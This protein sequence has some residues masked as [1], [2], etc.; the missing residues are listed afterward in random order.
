M[1]YQRWPRLA[2]VMLVLLLALGS[3]TLVF[4]AGPGKVTVIVSSEVVPV[5]EHAARLFKEKT[6]SD[7]EIVSQGYNETLQKIVTSQAAGSTAYDITK[8]DTIWVA[9]FAKSGFLVPLDSYFSTEFLN[10][11]L[12]ASIE[13]MRYQGKLWALGG[14]Y[15]AKFLYYNAKLLHDAGFSGPPPTWEDL[16]RQSKAMQSKGL[17]KFGTAWG[18]AQ[19]EGLVA[20]FTLLLNDFG[21]K[22]QDAAGR[23]QLNGP[24]AVRTL[25]FMRDMLVTDK[26]ADP[27]SVTLTD[28]DVVTLFI[29]GRI[30]FLVSWTFAWAWSQDPS[31]SKIP[32]DTRIALVP[33]T[34]EAR[35]VSSSTGGGSGHGILKNSR[36]KERAAQLLRIYVSPEMQ[37]WAIT[38]LKLDQITSPSVLRDP[39]VVRQSPELADFAKQYRH[40]YPRPTL[41]WYAQWSNVMQLDLHKAL[42]GEMSPKQA[43]DD[44]QRQ[45][46]ELAKQFK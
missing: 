11:T 23:W 46:E 41:P 3:G 5:W 25:T 10:D 15:N 6:G 20:D 42:V 32:Y 43:L 16:V 35:T 18:W 34:A 22:Y 45:I 39:Q 38:T 9:Q 24:A 44:A 27:S 14:G 19:A 33:G 37:R 31:R 40:V 2:V 36:Q 7:V 13:Q 30:P 28:R 29:E 1:G 4:G 8:V 26:V 12:P 17:A 21:G